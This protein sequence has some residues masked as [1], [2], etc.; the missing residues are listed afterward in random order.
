MRNS[1]SAVGKAEAKAFLRS[2]AAT[3]EPYFSAYDWLGRV[4]AANRLELKRRNFS[5]ADIE[6]WDNACRITFLLATL[7]KRNED[8]L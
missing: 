5:D 4:I 6:L 2:S 7:R 3:V 8:L 1:G